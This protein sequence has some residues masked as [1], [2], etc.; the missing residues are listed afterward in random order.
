[1]A[2]TRWWQL[3]LGA[4]LGALIAVYLP[5][6][7]FSIA[8]VLGGVLAYVTFRRDGDPEDDALTPVAAGYLVG[9]L[10]YGLIEL[11]LILVGG[12]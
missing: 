10:G 9:V 1:M 8:I 3:A 12:P 4:F 11:V 7:A 6:I 2:I 5:A